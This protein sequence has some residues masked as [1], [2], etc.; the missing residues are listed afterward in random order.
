[1]FDKAA[2]GTMGI[3]RVGQIV[4]MIHSGSRGLGH[5]VATD[6]LT[7]MERAMARDGISTNDRQLACARIQSPEG[8]DYLVRNP[9]SLAPTAV[10][11]AV[12]CSVLRLSLCADTHAA[13]CRARA[14]A[15]PQAAMACAA[16]YAWVN[17]S[18]MT[19]LCRQARLLTFHHAAAPQLHPPCISNPLFTFQPL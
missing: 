7:E 18:S 6:A 17:R 9:R 12:P 8:Q 10:P 11:V 15:D 19:F 16:N 2:A 14:P 1:M 3:D 5:Q 4:V 13:S